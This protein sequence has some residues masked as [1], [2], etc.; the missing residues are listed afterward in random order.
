VRGERNLIVQALVNLISNAVK[1]C[2]PVSGQVTVRTAV[3]PDSHVRVEVSDN[4][5][6]IPLEVRQRLFRPFATSRRSGEGT[7]LGLFIVRQ[8]VRKLG[9]R[10]R[11]STSQRGTTVRVDLPNANEA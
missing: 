7:G 8:A 9:G 2:A 4:G 6:G 3:L 5:P 1:A 11:L 10:L